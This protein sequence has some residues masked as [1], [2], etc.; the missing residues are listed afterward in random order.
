MDHRSS[1]I[2]EKSLLPSIFGAIKEKGSSIWQIIAE[3]STRAMKSIL[4][5]LSKT[6]PYAKNCAKGVSEKVKAICLQ[7]KKMNG[8]IAVLIFGLF[9]SSFFLFRMGRMIYEQNT[10]LFRRLYPA[11]EIKDDEG[12]YIVRNVNTRSR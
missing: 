10:P 12:S 4:D 11:W 9:L 6:S 1:E 3:W 8:T 5:S 2:V 7:D